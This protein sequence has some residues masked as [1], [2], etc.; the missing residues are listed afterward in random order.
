MVRQTNVTEHRGGVGSTTIFF[1][2]SRT[3]ASAP[4]WRTSVTP[5]TNDRRTPLTRD[6]IVDA[7]RCLVSDHGL[8]AL[9]L[10]RLADTLSVSATALYAHFDDKNDLLRAV[11]EREFDVLMACYEEIDARLTS[12]SPIER[13]REQFR[14]YVRRSQEDPELFRVMFLFPPDLGDLTAAP[15]G[16]ELPAATKTF[17]M[18]LR[19]IDDAIAAGEVVADDPLTIALSMW[20]GAHG[21]ANLLLLGL[22]PSADAK[23]AIVDEVA[24]RILAG[25][26]AAHQS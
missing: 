2:S 5:V 23:Q 16:A 19:A 1:R 15:E 10:R 9:T 24:A 6:G 21:V 7:A 22:A 17:N 8:E 14:T 18:A 4:R 3:L 26:G 20:A 13:I 12:A 11:A 25:Y